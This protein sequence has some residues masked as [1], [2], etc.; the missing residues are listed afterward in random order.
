M[1]ENKLTAKDIF[2]QITEL[3]RQLTENSYTSLHRL[4]DAI[5]SLESD[6]NENEDRWEQIADICDVFK[7]RELTL[8]KMLELYEKMYNDIQKEKANEQKIEPAQ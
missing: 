8:L 7:T 2:V 1:E 3:Q 4:S 5:S 6:S